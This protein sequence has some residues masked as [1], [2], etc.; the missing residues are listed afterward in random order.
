MSDT[1][2]PQRRAKRPGIAPTPRGGASEQAR[3]QAAAILEVLAGVRR[4]SEAAQALGTSLPR[5]YQLEQRALVGLVSA[6][7]PA[8]R[9]PRHNHARQLAKLEREK[10]RLQRECDRH[11]ALVRVAQRSLGLTPPTKPPGKVPAA[12]T[13]GTAG[14]RRRNRRPVVRALR[15]AHML[16][17]EVLAAEPAVEDS[18]SVDALA[19]GGD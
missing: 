19:V 15:A 9:G 3:R 4:P 1:P 11:Q 10:Q 13:D 12:A 16:A 6:C 17:K 5:Y 18:P 14:K 2:K 8:A 7:E